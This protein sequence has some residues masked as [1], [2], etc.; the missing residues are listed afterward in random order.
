MTQTLTEILADADQG[1]TL[2]EK[3][4]DELP[5]IPAAYSL[6]RTKRVNR[7][8]MREMLAEQF[9]AASQKSREESLK[10]CEEFE[11]VDRFPS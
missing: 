8:K 3:A 7:K 5:R 11:A 9:K 1:L 6:Q 2:R 4:D 10:V